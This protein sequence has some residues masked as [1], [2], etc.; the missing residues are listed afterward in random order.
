MNMMA[1]LDP[2]ALAVIRG[3]IPLPVLSSLVVCDAVY[4]VRVRPVT[5]RN[6]C[7]FRR[8]VRLRKRCFPC[9]EFS[10]RLSPSSPISLISV[11]SPLFTLVSGIFY[12]L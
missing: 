6:V 9:C 10:R 8:L 12:L 7:V 11:L 2:M 5:S 1:C 3:D 4:N